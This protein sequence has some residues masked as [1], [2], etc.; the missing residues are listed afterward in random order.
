MT[1][2]APG[3]MADCG[4]IEPAACERAIALARAGNEADLV[5]TR[6]IVVDD[7]CPPATEC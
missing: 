4:R 7:T 6:L 5:G 1:E 2:I 3:V